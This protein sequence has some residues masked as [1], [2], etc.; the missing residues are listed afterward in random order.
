M[1]LNLSAKG[2]SVS[3]DLGS[4]S[5]EG[6]LLAWDQAHYAWDGTGPTARAIPNLGPT[7]AAWSGGK[8]WIPP[9]G[10]LVF[11]AGPSPTAPMPPRMLLRTQ[12]S[13][14][15]RDGDTLVV[16][17]YLQQK[18][19]RIASGAY[20]IDSACSGAPCPRGTA[21]PLAAFDGAWD[22]SLEGSVLRIPGLSTGDHVVRFEWQG[23]DGGV[24]R[25][26]VA[27]HVTGV[28]RAARWIDRFDAGNLGSDLPGA[29]S[30]S[31]WVQADTATSRALLSEPTWSD[32][33]ANKRWFQMDFVLTQPADLSYPNFVAA[34]LRIPRS[35]LDS[36]AT[37]WVG[38]VF[39][40]AAA[41]D[42]GAG[43][44][45]LII[46]E[47]SVK[48]YDAH[49]TILAS[50]GGRW[51]RDTL[52]WEGFH[53]GGWGRNVGPLEVRQIVE[54]QFR[55]AGAGRGRLQLDNLA[56]LGT[57]G[58]AL[59][60]RVR[61]TVSRTWSVRQRP[62]SILVEA[63]AGSR[64]SRVRLLDPSGRELFRGAGNGLIGVP[65]RSPGI[66]FL[67]LESDGRREV[68]GIG[69]VR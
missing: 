41:Y 60:M 15:L 23:A 17:D 40:H 67:E 13:A 39:D 61:R 18:G 6:E 4:A 25:D 19:G 5:P 22:G 58:E 2:D 57:E 56:L 55:A 24:L 54:L 51:V 28:V 27:V 35:F 21:L 3:L 29:P 42:T 45:Q 66:R 31:K 20:W 8:A 16:T 52:Y 34:T 69:A 49:M 36:T 59:P 43:S 68:R 32:T 10:A 26:S 12:S 37:R 64:S 1:V 62:G 33:S 46:P 9:F 53:Q 65:L 44:F 11:R 30:W 7:A 50:T 14:L 63:P 48:D 47:D 38:I